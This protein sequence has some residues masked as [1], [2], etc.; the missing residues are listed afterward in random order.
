ML[1]LALRGG[2]GGGVGLVVLHVVEVKDPGDL[3]DL[4]GEDGGVGNSGIDSWDLSS[5]RLS[6]G[7]ELRSV[8]GELA[9]V[10]AAGEMF[11]FCTEFSA[12]A[13]LVLRDLAISS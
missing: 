8:G 2:I 3:F 4:V 11:S 5:G 1:R 9:W 10:V 13:S 6:I 7:V 12:S